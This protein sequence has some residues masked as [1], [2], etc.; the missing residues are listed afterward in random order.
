MQHVD[1]LNETSTLA[2]Y[3]GILCRR[4]VLLDVSCR[5]VWFDRYHS[6]TQTQTECQAFSFGGS[7]SAPSHLM[8]QKQQLELSL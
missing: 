3:F 6:H 7:K 4:H 5:A 1:T 8:R 2:S